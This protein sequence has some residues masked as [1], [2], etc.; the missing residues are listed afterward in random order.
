MPDT[1]VQEMDKER[2]G[3]K[4]QKWRGLKLEATPNATA[5]IANREGEKKKKKNSLMQHLMNIILQCE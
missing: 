5:R 3:A 1:S 4:E 2:K